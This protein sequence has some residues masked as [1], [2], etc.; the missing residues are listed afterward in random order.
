MAAQRI[1]FK[2]STRTTSENY[3]NALPMLLSGR[4]RLL[5][6]P[7]LRAQLAGLERRIQAG[8]RETVTHAHVASAHDDLAAA[9]CGA[10][11]IAGGRLAFNRNYAQWS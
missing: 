2:P 8:G 10:L 4:A 3:L 5:D 7:A 1:L 11:V 6:N 9:A